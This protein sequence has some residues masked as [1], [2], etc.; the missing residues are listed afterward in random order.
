MG[1]R[2][3]VLAALAVLVAGCAL[4]R[5]LSDVPAA[6]VKP[7]AMAPSFTATTLDG[8]QISLADYAGRPVVLNFWGSWCTP[9]RGEQPALE[10]LWQEFR[11]AGVQFLGV[12]IRDSRGN[13]RAYQEEFKVTYPSIFDRPAE[14]AARYQVAY[15]P[16]TVLI[17][18]QGR[19]VYRAA[20]AI[21][22]GELRKL[23]AIR[24]LAN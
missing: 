6:P 8:Q 19:L 7:G 23:I 11:G 2:A 5:D 22:E 3:A 15:P 13:A 24:L 17:D 21:Q 16:S 4:Q 12:N 1:W 9:C 18:G 14:L 10:K 20:G